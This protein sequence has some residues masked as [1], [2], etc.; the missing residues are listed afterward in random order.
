M[1]LMW[2][3]NQIHQAF[4]VHE[5]KLA[6][7]TAESTYDTAMLPNNILKYQ[8]P[9]NNIPQLSETEPQY[10][11]TPGGTI[12]I[13]LIRIIPL[14]VMHS[15]PWIAIHGSPDDKVFWLSG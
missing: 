2:D 1:S 14:G 9:E 7:V 10:I 4:K 8:L 5:Y 15:R 6:L 13:I 12:P 3:C 11:A